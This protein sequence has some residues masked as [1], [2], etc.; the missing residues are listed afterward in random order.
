[1]QRWSKGNK[2]QTL[3]PQPKVI[4]NN[5]NKYLSDVDLLRLVVYGIV[6]VLFHFVQLIAL[7]V[8]EVSRNIV[9][10]YLKIEHRK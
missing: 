10:I 6:N 7:S 8:K 9:I 4:N 2:A 1:M 5:Y 3:A